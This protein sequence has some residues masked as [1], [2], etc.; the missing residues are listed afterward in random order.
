MP[1][2]QMTVWVDS[3]HELSHLFQTGQWSK[4]EAGNNQQL[5][6]KLSTDMSSSVEVKEYL[7]VSSSR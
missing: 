7:S 4:K 5:L 2:A 3:N 1:A 6:V